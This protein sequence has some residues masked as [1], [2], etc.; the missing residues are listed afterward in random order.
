MDNR[1]PKLATMNYYN[2]FTEIEE[3]FVKRR[4]K[5]LLISPMDWSL[6]AT[7]RDAGVPLQVAIRGIDMAMDQFH[8]RPKHSGAKINSLFYC[9]DSVM[10]EYANYLESHVGE[11]SE[12]DAGQPKSGGTAAESRDEPGRTELVEFVSARI[13]E[14]KRIPAKQSLGE[15]ACEGMDRVLARLEEIAL[16]LKTDAQIDLEVLERDLGIVDEILIAEL[17]PMIPPEQLSAWEKETKAE[18]GVY[19]KRLPRETYDKIRANYLRGKIHQ[20]FDIEELSFF[21]L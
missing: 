19:R 18:L 20:F 6:I 10:T 1:W 2:Y 8:A 17:R 9:H 15:R 5:H 11:H 7:W 12:G 16:N 4:G 13:D 21:R 3:H 14:I